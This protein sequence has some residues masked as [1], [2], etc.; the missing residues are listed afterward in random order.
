M[1]EGVALV[2]IF[3][4]GSLIWR[5]GFPYLRKFDGF[6][7]GWARYFWQGSTD[8]RGTQEE[9]GRVVTLV[10]DPD[11]VIMSETWGTVYGIPEEEAEIIL[12]NLDYREKG[13]YTREEVDVY[14]R[15]QDGPVVKKAILYIGSQKNSCYLGE[16]P[17]EVIARQIYKCVGPSGPNVDYLINLAESMRK[18]NVHDP[19]V[20][21][22]ERMVKELVLLKPLPHHTH[23][24]LIVNTPI[25]VSPDTFF[26]SPLDVDV[27]PPHVHTTFSSVTAEQ[28]DLQR[29]YFFSPCAKVQ[30]V[31]C[32]DDGAVMAVSQ[33]G[34]SLLPAGI[35]DIKGSFKA[36]DL[37]SIVN[38][39]GEEVSRGITFYASEEIENIKGQH[40]SKISS[41]LGFSRGEV[42]VH[43]HNMIL[44]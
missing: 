43:N 8:H 29:K 36:Q 17:V 27:H 16:T 20:A 15:G 24:S 30:G 13:G 39:H 40:S 9:P 23:P 28:N 2:Y 1:C 41:I 32:V 35:L 7:K 44:V 18:M 3:G 33:R 42:V 31:I 22:L 14:I 19:H 4:Y 5:P 25:G 10:K 34:R 26:R 37:V 12:K 11:E 38:K 21:D 6:I